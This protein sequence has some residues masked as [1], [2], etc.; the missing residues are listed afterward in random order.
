[1]SVFTLDN[2]FINFS[3]NAQEMEDEIL[4][5]GEVHSF[6]TCFDS[7]RQGLKLPREKKEISRWLG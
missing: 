3:W 1:M 4:V 7:P 5:C 2:S 6:L